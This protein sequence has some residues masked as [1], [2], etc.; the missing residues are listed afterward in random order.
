MICQRDGCDNALNSTRATKKYCSTNC[1]KL[2]FR[3]QHTGDLDGFVGA[4]E[5]PIEKP[6]IHRRIKG[7]KAYETVKPSKCGH[8]VFA[9]QRCLQKS[10]MPGASK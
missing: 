3:A 9:G 5:E 6:E 4:P 2:A 7:A 10:C 1:R 8:H